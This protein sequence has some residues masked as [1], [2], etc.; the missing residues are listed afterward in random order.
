MPDLDCFPFCSWSSPW[1][2]VLGPYGSHSMT[3]SWYI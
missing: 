2:P 3:S 1:Q